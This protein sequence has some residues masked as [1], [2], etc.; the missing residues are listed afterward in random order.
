M[1]LHLFLVPVPRQWGHQLSLLRR[2]LHSEKEDPLQ[3]QLPLKD[4][5]DGVQ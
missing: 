4:S 3:N 5:M 2:R 1:S